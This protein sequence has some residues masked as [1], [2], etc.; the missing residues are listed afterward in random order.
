MSERETLTWQTYGT[1]VRE[2]AQQ[3]ADAD[4]VPDVVLGIARGGLIPAGSI[5]YALDC[6]NLFTMNVEFYTGVGTTLEVPTMLPPYLNASELDDARVLIVDDV[7]DSGKTLEMVTDFCRDHVAQ[8]RTA[9]IYEKPR[10]AI[11]ADFVWKRT[12]LWINFPWSTQPPVTDRSG[13]RDA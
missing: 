9:V 11:R 3:V 4:F 13:V 5:A 7:A 10:T 12:D 2:L 8:A 1:A 6:K